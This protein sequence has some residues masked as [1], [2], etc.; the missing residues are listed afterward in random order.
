[1]LLCFRARLSLTFTCSQRCFEL[2]AS[3]NI[4]GVP[5]FLVEIPM[6]QI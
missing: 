4:R 3:H 5:R 1:M 2:V 6:L